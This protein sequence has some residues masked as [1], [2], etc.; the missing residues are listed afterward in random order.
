MKL[1]TLGRLATTGGVRPE[2][3]QIQ[4]IQAR[5][6]RFVGRTAMFAVPL[7]L[8]MAAGPLT[9]QIGPTGGQGGNTG[10]GIG[11]STGGNVGRT[12][13]SP[14]QESDIMQRPIFI[15]G[16]VTLPDGTPPPEPV[17]IE[18]VCAGNVRTEGFTDRKG[19]FSFE[20][21]RSN[22][23]QDASMGGSDTFP[24]GGM[25]GRTGSVGGSRTGS[26]NS[27]G[28]DSR[29]FGCELRVTLAGYTS[30]S[31]DLTTR[32]VMDNP[33]L[34]TFI[35]RRIGNAEGFTLSA[36]SALA[37]NDARK[38]YEKGMSMS[39]KKP[40]NQKEMD[41]ALDEAEKH[42]AKA[43]EVYPKYAAAWTELGQVY[44]TQKKFAEARKAYEQSV[45]ADGKFVPPYH[46]MAVLALRDANWQD[47]ADM[48]DKVL[49]LDPYTYPD[50]FYLSSVGNLQLNHLDIAEK[51]AREALK[52][53]T[54]KQNP[55]IHYVLGLVLAQKRQF[56]SAAESL[57][58]F[59][60]ASPDAKD[61]DQI[62][63][64]LRQIEELGAA[65][66]TGTQAEPQ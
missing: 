63:Q 61:A 58:T 23:F 11:G 36:T 52:L 24:S 5:D 26:R 37:P 8:L 3:N 38:E 66:R 51:N 33:E 14:T 20:L 43:V 42:F 54:R 46:R 34:G 7:A 64:Q 57:R 28:I 48:S 31:V 2:A 12:T 60:E 32:R 17:R 16:K 41:Q 21:G 50:A 25:A 62:R 56:G 39:L 9:A 27:M 22:E 47:L 44:E 49:R 65:N 13:T 19:R 45:A 35:L 29:L 40:K 4:F 1:T 59:L 15:S 10:G 18:R 6:V 30:Q 55:R 53:D